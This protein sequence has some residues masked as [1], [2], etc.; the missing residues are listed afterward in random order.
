MGVDVSGVA[1][2][3]TTGGAVM[4]VELVATELGIAGLLGVT[5]STCV[6]G[7]T[8]ETDAAGGGPGVEVRA[9]GAGVG[10]GAAP[11]AKNAVTTI[12]PATPPP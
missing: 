6:V 4:V 7:V 8:S 5:C 10:D 1:A 3:T 2:A 11:S 12:S 9:T